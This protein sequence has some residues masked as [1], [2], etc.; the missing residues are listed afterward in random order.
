MCWIV[1]IIA[2]SNGNDTS[3]NCNDF[4]SCNC[5]SSDQLKW[6]N[7]NSVQKDNC[8]EEE[9]YCD[10]Y[11]I[12]P[13]PGGLDGCNLKMKIVLQGGLDFTTPERVDL[14]DE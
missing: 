1:S 13:R 14:S 8:T 12:V 3:C 10:Y 4:K 2:T 11:F 5:L 7:E 9:D 6:I